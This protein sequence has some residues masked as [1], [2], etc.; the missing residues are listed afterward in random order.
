MSKVSTIEEVVEVVMS[1]APSPVSYMTR[2]HMDYRSS[3]PR[4]Q[5]VDLR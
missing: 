4:I 5:V 3:T 2:R 1:F